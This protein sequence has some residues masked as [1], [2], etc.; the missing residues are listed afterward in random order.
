M[1][2]LTITPEMDDHCRAVHEAE[3]QFAIIAPRLSWEMLANL[4]FELAELLHDARC[5]DSY[6]AKRFC[7][8]TLWYSEVKPILVRIVGHE[9]PDYHPILGTSAAYE[10]AYDTILEAMPACRNCSCSG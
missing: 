9:R 4:E 2:R 1:T 10:I 5:A 7:R 6:D 8:E 3:R